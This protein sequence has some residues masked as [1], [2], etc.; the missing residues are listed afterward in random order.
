MAN[1]KTLL[2]ISLLTNLVLL[3]IVISGFIVF[4][5]KILTRIHNL[6]KCE[7]VMFGDSLTAMGKWY[8]LLNNKNVVNSGT[9]GHTSSHLR[10]YVLAKVIQHKPEMCFVMIGHN[11]LHT[12]VPI[13][14]IAS[15]YSYIVKK[16][17]QNEIEP[18]LQSTLFVNNDYDEI[19]NAQTDSL[20]ALIIEIANKN[21]V[22]FMDINS[23]LSEN[24]RLIK[25]YTS[26]GVHLNDEG[27]NLW[28]NLLNEFISKK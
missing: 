9:N 6:G 15:N 12:G 10:R 2:K 1:H 25:H 14:K 13:S 3:I 23:V 24:K 11:D 17:L 19:L 27:Y 7:I 21:Q 26:D 20:N 8:K 18:I 5:H 28:S 4:K 22:K 16:L